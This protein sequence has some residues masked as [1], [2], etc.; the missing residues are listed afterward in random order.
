MKT[1]FFVKLAFWAK[2]ILSAVC[3]GLLARIFFKKKNFDFLDINSKD[4]NF[5]KE[6]F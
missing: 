1:L 6:E 5:K 4:F 2:M 3:L